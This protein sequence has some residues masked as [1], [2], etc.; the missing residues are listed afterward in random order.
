MGDRW[1]RRE[2]LRVAG[3]VAAGG[4]LFSTADVG[5][6]QTDESWP[7]V[8]H[9]AGNT[10]YAP[11]NAGPTDG[12][13]EAWRRGSMGEFA[14]LAVADGVVYAAT[15]DRLYALDASDGSERWRFEAAD[16]VTHAAAAVVDGVVYA[17]GEDALYALSASDG[18]ERW[19]FETNVELGPTVA[20]GTVSVGG[21]NALY[22]LDTSDG[23]ERWRVSTPRR[24]GDGVPAIAD[25]TVYVDGSDAGLYA[26]S[27]SDGSERWRFE[28][29][30][31]T[32][33]PVAADGAVY[34][35][36]GESLVA[37]SA[38][39]G[40]ER[41]R[42]GAEDRVTS[43]PAV[44]DGVVYVEDGD[45]LRALSASD[46]SDRWRFGTDG[47]VFSPA[48]VDG[49]VYV[50]CVDHT[51]YAV[52]TSDGSERWRFE[53]PDWARSPVV[54]GGTVYVYDGDYRLHALTS[55]PNRT[56]SA[57]V[58]LPV[59]GPSGELFLERT[60]PVAA[61]SAA[62]LAGGVLW[63][64]YRRGGGED[65]PP[66]RDDD[67]PT[68]LERIRDD[69]G[70]DDPDGVS[71]PKEDV[72]RL[73]SDAADGESGAAD[74]DADEDGTVDPAADAIEA[75][76]SLEVEAT[77]LAA[78]GEYDRAL[79][80]LDDAREA[81]RRARDAAGGSDAVDVDTVD[82]RLDRLDG[83][84]REIQG[85]RFDDGLGWL[86]EAAARAGLLADRLTDAGVDGRRRRDPSADTERAD[87]GAPP[88]S[89]PRAPDVS[90]DY[91]ALTDEEPIGGGGN[92]DV[93]KATLPTPEGD[94]TLAIKRPRMQGTLHTDAVERLM[95]EAETWDKLD[96]HDH[97][98]GVVD[99]DAEPLPWIA[100]E[101]MD[102]GDLGERAG[103]LDF[104]QALWTALGITKGVRHAHRKG[105]A[106]LDLKPA[107]VLLRSVEGAWDVP[108]VA[109]WG[110]S[111]HLL[112]HSASVEG[113]SPQYAAPEQFDDEFGPVDEITDVYQLGTVLYELFVGRPPF[114]GKPAKTMHRVLH[115]T[116]TPPSDL[117][118]LPPELDDIL[119]K[120]LAKEKDDRYESVLYLRDA[121]Q[122]VTVG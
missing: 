2:A 25:G 52:D 113:L 27:A 29:D 18:S 4:T 59:I 107:N 16:P 3:G 49:T 41:W 78:A 35:G 6:A 89:I 55:G 77:N 17:V 45:G 120:A 79:S 34:V 97:I 10:G 23:S 93:T 76:D 56:G 30:R 115:E 83:T 122:D 26:F 103:E 68:A 92:A 19:R 102:A 104:D 75:G 20:D 95:A 44:A 7:Q 64:R 88:E 108:K 33:S 1:T 62:A 105:V 37:L 63:R 66:V 60:W 54:A 119:L 15:S 32:T 81:Y 70:E 22:A 110:L 117:T 40:S 51:L 80:L 84:E 91:D 14:S 94:V 96:D 69:E 116:P 72:E 11:G 28:T 61:A 67:T 36:V 111:K 85:L 31:S 58:D 65:R 121:L 74:A 101:Y 9:D 73:R 71:W 57:G 106:H 21:G 114:E 42:S 5:S 46:G 13:R 53:L 24:V 118:D 43:A 98:V 48:V 109:D 8:G 50:G 99:Y 100:M 86:R 87:R 90:V 82:G 39:D 12:V 112:D 47:G 38:S